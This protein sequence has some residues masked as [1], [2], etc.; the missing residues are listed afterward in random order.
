M[1]SLRVWLQRALSILDKGPTH[2]NNLARGYA[3]RWVQRAA[4]T[5]A[6]NRVDEAAFLA[7]TRVKGGPAIVVQHFRQRRQPVFFFDPGEVTAISATVHPDDQAR[8]IA[9]AE[10]ACRR[11]FTFR[12]QPPVV[13]HDE[14]DWQH[15]PQG[16]IDWTWELN[17]HAY[18]VALGRAFAYTGDTKY[19]QAFRDLLTHWMVHNPP[20][21]GAPNWDSPL[22]VA[23]RLN[24]WVWAYYCFRA[25]L[26][27]AAHLACLRGL[28]W[29]GRFLAANLEYVSPNNHLLLE[30]KALALGGLLF[31][32]FQEASAWRTLGLEV[33]WREVRRQ[34]HPDGGH[35]EQAPMYHQIVAA[36]L[37][38]LL[39]LLDLN[40]VDVPV[41]I[42]RR[43]NRMLEFEQ[44]LRKPDG[45]LPLLGDS[46]L[47]DSYARCDPLVA[48][49]AWLGRPELMPGRL[50]ETGLWLTGTRPRPGPFPAAGAPATQAFPET[51]YFVMRAGAGASVRYLVFDCGPFGYGPAPGHGHADALSFE[52]YADGRTWV[53]DPGVYSY[54]LG[55]D[56][57]NFFRSTAAHNTVSVDALDQ[58]I[59]VGV[60]HVLRPA[61]TTLRHWVSAERVDFVDGEHD[62]YQRL[63]QPIRHR[64]QILFVK[65]DY[66]LVLD[67]LTG[68]GRHRYDWRLHLT[69][70]AEVAIGP[71]VALV[72]V[73]G[74]GDPGLLVAWAPDI[75]AQVVLGCV[76]PIQGWVSRYS[77]E[78]QP[79]PV[80]CLTQDGPAPVEFA[81]VLC[82]IGDSGPRR[83]VVRT[84]ASEPG[85]GR[86][87]IESDRWIDEIVIDRRPQAGVKDLNGW[88]TTGRL[89]CARRAPTD[90]AWLWTWEHV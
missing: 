74:S 68:H 90:T 24:V 38:E 66:W 1:S 10:A 75:P 19:Y 36:E 40:G 71:Q 79:A 15:C 62:G 85:V 88:R 2:L 54:H 89:A 78:K 70:E 33:T 76:D 83:L 30:A 4:G 17:R 25:R 3:G 81:A 42:R 60:Q 72:S 64:R 8:T 7:Q 53:V 73:S 26:D 77:G 51:G 82:P 37:V 67:Q 22:E 20:G 28:W 48:G 23:F 52:L 63:A 59:L 47:G 41:D 35:A 49:A 87:R 13:F 86:L 55:A 9:V 14:V 56:W 43:V 58:S 27:E 21:V 69:A 5:W 31:P 12:S 65:P 18:F 32:E 39:W 11:T 46:A 29:H 34:V 50:D 16:N 84:L 80:I 44:A 57:R 61:R 45:E 6:S